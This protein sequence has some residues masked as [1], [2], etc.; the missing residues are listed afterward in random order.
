MSSHLA[1]SHHTVAS[2]HPASGIDLYSDRVLAD[3]Y[4]HYRTL[5]DAG[6]AVWLERHGAWALPRYASVIEALRNPQVFSSAHG[7][8][9]NDVGNAAQQ[10]TM[11]ASDDP[12]HASLRK[13]FAEPLMPGALAPLRANLAAQADALVERLVAAGTFDAVTDLAHFLP[14]TVVRSLVGLPAQGCEH[15]LE[16]AAAMFNAFGPIDNA[17]TQAAFPVIGEVA[18]Y[19]ADERTLS[20]LRPGSWSARL[21]ECVERGQLSRTQAITMLLDYTGPALDTTINATSSVM[22]LFTQWPEQWDLVRSDPTLI[23][24]A[25][26]EAVRLESPIRAFTRYV[27]RQHDVQG[28]TVETG[29][30][31]LV[32]YASA[33]RDERHWDDP[34]RFD[35]R[36]RTTGHVGF[37]HG[38]HLCAGMHLARLEITCL[39]EALARRVQRFELLEMERSLHNTLRG[40]RSLRIRAIAA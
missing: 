18:A 4:P 21:L 32:L 36:R 13:I 23:R 17:R 35:I 34:E 22:W 39:L 10:G 19:L 11:L 28:V 8:T 12:L 16:W 14:L 5:R 7:C 2:E 6:P 29:A 24:G 30:R 3:P 27:T 33:N 40:I 38:P 26:E 1:G 37:G 20:D 25:I 31:V 15:M 9:L